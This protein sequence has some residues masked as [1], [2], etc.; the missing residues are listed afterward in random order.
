MFAGTISKHYIVE[1]PKFRQF[2]QDVDA[3]WD[4][5]SCKW[6]ANTK[7]PELEMKLKNKLKDLVKYVSDVSVTLDIWTDSRMRSIWE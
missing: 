4:P 1:N 2:M 3:L 5:V 6:I 7:L